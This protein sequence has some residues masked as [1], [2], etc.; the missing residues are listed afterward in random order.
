MHTQLR[1]R[2]R[3]PPVLDWLMLG[4]SF[5]TLLFIVVAH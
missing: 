3:R 2:R 1:G 4:V 5:A